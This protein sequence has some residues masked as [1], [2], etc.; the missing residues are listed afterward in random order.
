MISGEEKWE[1]A[2]RL[3]GKE[4]GIYEEGWFKSGGKGYD[5]FCIGWRRKEYRDRKQ[6]SNVAVGTRPVAGPGKGLSVQEKERTSRGKNARKRDPEKVHP[7][8]VYK[9]LLQREEGL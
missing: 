3:G 5:L 1:K 6:E 9:R 7:T 8:E 4:R 2:R